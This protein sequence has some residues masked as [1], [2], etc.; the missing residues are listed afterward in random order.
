MLQVAAPIWNEVAKEGLATNFGKRL[1]RLSQEQQNDLLDREANVLQQQGH[2]QKAVRAFQEVA[3]LLGERQ[4]IARFV[5]K[6]PGQRQALPEV[7]SLQ[8]AVMLA[9]QSHLLTT[10]Q[11]RELENLLKAIN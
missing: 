11:Q 8:E 10:P 2:S 4:A 5:K 7:N 6:N 1:F 3:P 9:S